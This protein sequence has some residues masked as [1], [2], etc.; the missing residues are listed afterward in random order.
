[1]CGCSD[2][3]EFRPAKDAT[4]YAPVRDAYRLPQAPPECIPIGVVH[5]YSDGSIEDIA[6]TAARH[7]GTHYVVRTDKTEI[8]GYSG[9]AVGSNGFASVN[10]TA[11]KE[12]TLWAQ[13]YRC[14]T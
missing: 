6:L 13:I 10:L 9:V 1:M 5:A 7:G 3:A 11:D 2:P 8:T 14:P 12:R 4:S